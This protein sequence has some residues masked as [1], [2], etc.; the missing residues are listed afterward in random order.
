MKKILIIQGHPD[1]ESYNTALA[2][3][4]KKGAIEAGAEIKEIVIRD[5]DFS[6]NLKYG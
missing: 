2:K 6:P 5:L 4:Y 1:S 3:A